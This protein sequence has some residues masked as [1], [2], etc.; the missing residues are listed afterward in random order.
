MH[1]IARE[2]LKISRIYNI[3]YVTQIINMGVSLDHTLGRPVTAQTHRKHT[4]LAATHLLCPCPEVWHAHSTLSA[5]QSKIEF[6]SYGLR[7]K[8]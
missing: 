4:V 8:A 6:P 1:G 5:A 7:Q 3:L 2:I